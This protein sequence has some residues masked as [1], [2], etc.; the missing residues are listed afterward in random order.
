MN[1]KCEHH[2]LKSILRIIITQIMIIIIIISYNKVRLNVPRMP[3][4]AV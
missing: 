2:C 4:M 1:K 3:Q